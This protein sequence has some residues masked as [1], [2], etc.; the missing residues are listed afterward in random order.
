MAQSEEGSRKR[1]KLDNGLVQDVKITNAARLHDIL[2]FRQSTSPEVKTGAFFLSPTWTVWLTKVGIN[3]FERFLSVIAESTSVAEQ[4][5][6]L[7]I[8]KEYCHE[9]SSDSNDRVDFPDLLSTWSFA[10]QAGDEAIASAVPAALAQFFET[11]SGH[12]DF[13]EFGLSLCHS[14]LKRDQLRLFGRGLS[15]PR[16]KE[17]LISP[18]LWLLTEIV[19]FD[20]GTLA[21]KVFKHG[22]ILYKHLD[23]FLDHRPVLS[24]ATPADRRQPTIRHMALRLLLANLKYLDPGATAELI[25]HGKTLL[26]AIRN[27][28]SDRGDIV[29][30]ILQAIDQH[31]I[32]E[33]GIPRQVK[34]RCLNAGTLSALAKLYDYEVVFEED[35]GSSPRS[36]KSVRDAVHELLM[37]ICTGKKGILTP[38][39]GW[40]PAG[41]NADVSELDEVV[42]ELGLDSPYYFDDYTASVPVKNGTLSTFIQTLKPGADVLQ[43]GLLTSIFTSAPELV[44][45]YFSKKTTLA[46]PPQDEPVWRGH[47]GFLFSVVQLPLPRNGGWPDHVPAMPPP[48]SIVIES[49]IPRPLDRA[50]IS[51]CF[52][53]NEEIMTM[54]A[55]R[56]MTVALEKLDS[57]LT[58]FDAAVSVSSLWS[59][60]IPKLVNLFIQR[61]PPLSEVITALQRTPKSSELTRTT[62]LECIAAFHKVVPEVTSSS[63][64]DISP[65]LVD[66]LKK[67]QSETPESARQ[68]P[69]RDQVSKLVEI[70]ALSPATKWWHKPDS[71]A[72]SPLMQL[73]TYSLTA[74]D[75]RVQRRAHRVVST[76]LTEKGVLDPD[77]RAF[78]ALVASLTGTKKWTPEMETF[79]FMDSCLTRTMQRPVKYLDQLEEAQHL[80]SDTR[81]LSLMACSVAE[82]WPFVLKKDDTRAI[83]NI[84][85]W[86]AR[87]FS[88]LDL[89]GEN[90]RVLQLFQQQMLTQADSHRKAKSAF[91]KALNKQRKKPMV[92]GDREPDGT[93]DT[94][95]AETSRGPTLPPSNAVEIDLDGVF[96][97]PA[98]CP[99]SLEGL[100][101]WEKADYEFEA[102]GGRLASLIQ[103]TTSPE[104]EIRLQTFQT[105]QSVMRSLDAS[106][107]TE[108]EP[109]YLLLGEFSETMRQGPGAGLHD[110]PLPSLV[111]AL[112][113]QL[114]KIVSDPADHMYSKANRFL[115]RGPVWD[116]DPSRLIHY[117]VDKILLS[118]PEYDDGHDV[119]VDRLLDTLVDGLRTPADME[120]YRRSNVFQRVLSLYW[121]PR[122]QRA[123]RRKILQ[124]VYRAVQA[125]GAD[126]LITRVGIRAWLSVVK[127][128]DNRDLGDRLERVIQEQCT[129]SDMERW[130]R[131]RPVFR[132]KTG[133]RQG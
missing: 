25:T 62:V 111:A 88:A 15:S 94:G 131:S 40:Y 48:L 60:A 109:V 79:Q 129:V 50:T 71:E 38:Q 84:S 102:S 72:V 22:D 115:L 91:E 119:E 32:E 85:E 1:R 7:K 65:T 70:A 63:K 61:T 76:K 20:G 130:E 93:V 73:L 29:V 105:L 4:A 10:S 99:S 124:L 77:T 28:S 82:Q 87:F 128:G 55:A 67:I 123:A 33:E 54:S 3:T 47:F 83:K 41:V 18:C 100:D 37:K 132:E 120:L 16:S 17:F 121:S 14:L 126:T 89:A 117:W 112:A 56:L 58:M 66:V 53:M 64:F 24:D 101:R 6:Q 34:V 90:F 74:Q 59:R 107:Y 81:P 2:H 86:I 5:R 95:D 46:V 31:M 103:C 92:L 68:G 9:Q 108:K 39:S 49:V 45:D 114:L 11:V 98:V 21:N 52:H 35:D 133:T 27:L 57:V 116:P 75:D 106:T 13:R 42:T 19:S 125:G 78:D 26:A 122:C 80:V 110:G 104:R 51:R 118:E 8:L 30:D 127:R 69:M 43:A 44:A 97:H 113:V 96:G 23:T 12:L 36:I